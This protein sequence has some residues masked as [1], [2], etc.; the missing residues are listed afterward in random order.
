MTVRNDVESRYVVN[1]RPVLV[2]LINN[3]TI[4]DVMTTEA[5]IQAYS[6]ETGKV[7]MTR[8]VSRGLRDFLIQIGVEK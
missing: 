8:R 4:D 1:G 2:R 3:P 5:R 6:L 7:D